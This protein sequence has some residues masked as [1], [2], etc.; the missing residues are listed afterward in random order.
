[1]KKVFSIEGLGCAHCA[2]KMEEEIQ[3]LPDVSAATLNFI[4]RKLTVEAPEDRM[5]GVEQQVR[6]ICSRIESNCRL[7]SGDDPGNAALVKRNYAIE[8]LGCAHCA[9][10]MEE[11][12]QKLP[13][14]SSATLNFIARKLTIQA[15][16][17]RI[18]AI[19]KQAKAIC[20]RIEPDCRLVDEGGRA[21]EGQEKKSLYRIIA[22]VLLTA[23]VW[24]L[25]LEGVP[26]LVAF[27]IPYAMVG[28]DVVWSAFRNL[29]TGQVFDEKFLMSIATIGAFCLGEYHEAVAVMLFYQ[30]GELFQ[31][32]AVGRSR[33]NIAALMDIRPDTA[34]VIRSGHEMTVSP[35][36]VALGETIHVRPGEK[37]PLDGVVLEGE[38]TVNTAALTGESLPR[39]VKAGER[40]LSG[41]VNLTGLLTVQVESLYGESTVAKILELVE[42]ASEKKA[43]VEA[44][45]TRFA[46]YYTPCVVI[47][48]LLLALVPPVL[49][50]QSWGEW[51]SRALIFLV[52][53][54]P[55]ALVISVPLSFFGGIG[56]A[57]RAGILMKGANDLETLSKV[58]TIV[59]DK[60]GT[61]TEGNFTVTKVHAE[62]CSEEALLE[63]AAAAEAYSNHPI[64][65]SIRVAYGAHIEE[66]RI[67][68]IQEHPGMGLEAVIDGAPVFAGN[69]KLMEQI[70][71]AY[72][73]PEQAGTVVYLA[74]A[75][76]YLGYILIADC[77]KH[78][79]KNALAALKQLGVKRIAMLTGDQK[80]VA[81]AVA[82]ELGVDEVRSELLPGDKVGAVEELLAGPGPLAFVGDGI[83][84]APVLTRAD[85]GIAMGA[86][87]SD[88]AIEAADVV[89]MDDQ[90]EKLP[91]AIKI[92]RK[93]MGIVRQNIVFALA[94]KGLVLILGAMGMANMWIAVFADVGVMVLAILNAMRALRITD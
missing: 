13:G 39:D 17:H 1:M 92:A 64:G 55:C 34:V 86:M 41:T 11:E 37:I 35:E 26:R 73:A 66:D 28:W 76:S 15:P 83:N 82:A 88:A 2:G 74:K 81:L 38:S 45:I 25:P 90:L 91:K 36:E 62:G 54:C 78:R 14:V 94:V 56:G 60:T 31:S 58:Q 87:G 12:I 59:F 3:K 53:S 77:I 21:M 42:N 27:L 72:E 84:D 32:I 49:L 44:F 46:K 57:S 69:A 80:K 24:V 75:N 68:E 5:P 4:A 20:R 33:K 43:R 52:V 8:G 9:G 71:V 40:V 70:S 48:A 85:V 51:V 10:K 19:E 50:G 47:G 22:A 89:L 16:E 30:V 93:T 23:I 67:G 61:L 79:A 6:E 65:E 7:I 63:L 29:L 18:A